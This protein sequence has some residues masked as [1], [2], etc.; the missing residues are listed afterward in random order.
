[1]LAQVL[2]L[3]AGASDCGS[4]SEEP[5]GIPAAERQGVKCYQLERVLDAGHPRGGA[6]ALRMESVW[7]CPA[8]LR[9][10]L[11]TSTASSDTATQAL[12]RKRKS[13]RRFAALPIGEVAVA[14]VRHSEAWPTTKAAF[15]FLVLIAY[16]C[17]YPTGRKST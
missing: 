5:R 11:G 3:P 14:R 17:G 13:T 10:D 9:P 8:G 6:L 16:W 15:E 4:S 7:N 2:T 1:M 12:P